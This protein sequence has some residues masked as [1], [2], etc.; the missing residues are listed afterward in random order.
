MPLIKGIGE[1]NPRLKYL[2]IAAPALIILLLIYHSPGPPQAEIIVN[3]L[4]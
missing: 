1:L 2:L 4:R 3:R